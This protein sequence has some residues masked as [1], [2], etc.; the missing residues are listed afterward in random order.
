MLGLVPGMS[1]TALAD[2]QIGSWSALNNALSGIAPSG[3]SESNPTYYKLSKGITAGGSDSAITVAS[4]RYVVLDLNGQTI[5]RNLSTRTENGWVFNVLGNLTIKDSGSG[6]TITGGFSE[7][8]HGGGVYVNQGGTFTMEGGTISGNKASDMNGNGGGVCVEAGGTFTMKSGTISENTAMYG[9]GVYVDQ[10]G[11]FTMKSGTISK[12]KAINNGM[13]G[14]VYVDGGTFSMESGTISMNEVP[15]STG[16]GVQV[17]R[18]GTFTIACDN[19]P[20]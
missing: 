15:G 11:A 9:G 3:E 7:Y 1:L 6:G 18:G 13:G 14:G 8:Y 10:G 12:N 16:G 17:D 19:I 4:G 20:V 5:N 2:T